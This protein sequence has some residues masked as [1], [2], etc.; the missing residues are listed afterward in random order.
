M[1]LWGIE[2]VNSRKASKEL[3]QHPDDLIFEYLGCHFNS[4]VLRKVFNLSVWL[5]LV[6]L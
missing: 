6:C 4:Y 1:K 5:K 3:F 2:M